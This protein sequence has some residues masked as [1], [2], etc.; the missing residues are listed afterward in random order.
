MTETF[1]APCVK[2]TKCTVRA[3]RNIMTSARISKTI[4]TSVPCSAYVVHETFTAPTSPFAGT[5]SYENICGVIG[6]LDSIEKQK[7]IRFNNN[8]RPSSSPRNIAV[9]T[10]VDAC[11]KRFRFYFS[12]ALQEKSYEKWNEPRVSFTGSNGTCNSCNVY[13]ILIDRQ[14][15]RFVY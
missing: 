13:N 12:R 1:E 11:S 7:W 9:R 5:E 15:R 4:S 2:F 8:N 14:S 3:V 6:M 10:V